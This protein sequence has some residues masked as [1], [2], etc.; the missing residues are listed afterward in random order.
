MKT[1]IIAL[2]VSFT[3]FSST[4]Q[5]WELTGNSSTNPGKNF[6]G[7]TDEKS[8]VLRT[9]NMERLRITA[10]G[11]VGIGTSSPQQKLD[12][13]G[14]INLGE[15]SG[16][17][18]GNERVL[19]TTLFRNV[20]I[21]QFAGN[22]DGGLENTGVGYHALGSVRGE[23][24]ANVAMGGY[25]LTSNTYGN[26]NSALGY[27]ALYANI[28][29]YDNT[30]CGTF[31]LGFNTTGSLNTAL[32]WL[33]LTGNL[34]GYNNTAT[35]FRALFNN[36]T[37][38]NNTAN[39]FYALATDS[40]GSYNTAIGNYTDI[41]EENITNSTII[42][43]SALAMA[44]NQV[45]IGN[46]EV[47]SIGGFTDWT[48]ISDGRVKKNIKNN[49]PGLTFINKL[50]PLT[51]NLDLDAADK[52][53]QRPAMKNKD[54]NII[55]VQQDVAARKAKEQM[56]YT[57]FIAQDV[58]RAAKEL[59]YDFSGVDV[60]KNEKDL[61]GLRYAAFVVPLVKAVQQQQQMIEALQKQNDG[62]QKNNADQR[63]INENLLKRL[64]Q[65]EATKNK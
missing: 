22:N 3:A 63:S 14:N 12:V 26:G 64:E 59:N 10:N 46:S 4:A 13:N 17:Y 18:I 19:H 56:I 49:V 44:S 29:G 58:E 39:G 45:R 9:D 21:G 6:L 51:Y 1:V 25:A 37:G 35:G 16:L 32:G 41:N 55:P 42:G 5:S 8:L 60:A 7:T 48:N 20:F 57:G 24:G 34:T 43:N 2:F 11:K 36:T 54:G 65:L 47:T 15:G 40:T 28:K 38:N 62:L 61:Y 23:G 33:A 27:G 52:I 53:V 30:A 50:N 31:A